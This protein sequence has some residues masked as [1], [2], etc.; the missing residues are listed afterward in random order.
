MGY[1]LL[2]LT[3]LL[4]SAG[5]LCQ[6][7]AAIVWGRS[8]GQLAGQSVG[9]SGGRLGRAGAAMRWVLAAVLLL[10]LGM[11]AWLAVLRLLPVSQAYP[12]LSLNFVLVALAARFVFAEKVSPRHWWGVAAIISG[13]ILLGVGA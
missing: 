9:P 11:V 4:T 1:L 12:M 2:L 10:C 8:S 3:S 7:Q 6:K 5:Q 13:V